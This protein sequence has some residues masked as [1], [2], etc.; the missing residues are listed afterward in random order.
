MHLE[1]L[2]GRPATRD[3]VQASRDLQ[4]HHLGEFNQR[5]QVSLPHTHTYIHTHNIPIAR[6]HSHTHT[7]AHTY[8]HC[9]VQIASEEAEREIH[10]IRVQ[11]ARQQNSAREMNKIFMESFNELELS[12]MA[13]ACV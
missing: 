6:T 1:V 2:D 12:I 7:H 9:S 10:Q 8:T 4:R 11:C 5:I 13:G 3:E